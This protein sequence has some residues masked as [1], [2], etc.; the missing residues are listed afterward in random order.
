M[1]RLFLITVLGVMAA[2]SVCGCSPK[3]SE[4]VFFQMTDP[5]IGFR[6]KSPGYVHSDSLFARAVLAVDF[7]YRLMFSTIRAKGMIPIPLVIITGDLVN[8]QRDALQDSIYRANRAK[9]HFPVYEIPGNHDI[10]PW[11]P[12][13]HSNYLALRGYDRFSFR[14]GG[15]SFIGIDSNCIVDSSDEDRGGDVKISPSD[16]AAAAQA[17]AEQLEWL[18]KQLRKAQRCRYI[19]VFM[20]C[21]VILKDI[22]EENNYFNFPK[23]KRAEYIALFKEYGVDVVFAGHTHMDYDTTAEGIRFVTAGP[24]GSPL[25][26]GYS[27]FELVTVSKDSV[28]CTFLPPYLPAFMSK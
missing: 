11:T 1:R 8:D 25:G 21:P 9:I 18:R 7:R 26:R 28:N 24:V 14:F 6:D 19:F 23:K 10:R 15:C 2:L 27:G 20:H 5:Q 13:N 12:E 16:K 17:E 3:F 22:D 4:F